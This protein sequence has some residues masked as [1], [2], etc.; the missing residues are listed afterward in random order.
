MVLT[1]PPMSVKHTCPNCQCSFPASRAL[2][3]EPTLDTWLTT[4][5]I[6]TPQPAEL[7]T[8]DI[9]ASYVT[10]CRQEGR[11]PAL[12]Q[13]RL[14]RHLRASGYPFKHYGSMNKIIGYTL[15]R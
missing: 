8:N 15:R 12:T 5:L 4:A 1:F 13:S 3:F 6:P 9:Y 10:W 11:L 2:T 14:T 7:T